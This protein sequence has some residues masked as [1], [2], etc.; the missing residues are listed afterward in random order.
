MS[1]M[2]HVILITILLGVIG[3]TLY[4]ALADR[5]G[6]SGNL[7]SDPETGLEIGAKAPDFTLETLE[8]EGDYAE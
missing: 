6:V 7:E 5:V 3:F 4:E 1:R 2:R 8:G